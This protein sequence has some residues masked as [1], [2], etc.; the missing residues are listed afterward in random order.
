M[1][2]SHKTRTLHAHCETVWIHD[3]HLERTSLRTPSIAKLD[4]H[5]MDALV[6]PQSL[7]APLDLLRI[8]AVKHLPARIRQRI[9]DDTGG[10][11]TGASGSAKR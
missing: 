9:E 10:L 4:G 1:L 2:T 5:P 7:A 6:K 3:A 11:R 8:C